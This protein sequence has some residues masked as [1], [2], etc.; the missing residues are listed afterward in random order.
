M[1]NENGRETPELLLITLLLRR[2]QIDGLHFA[3]LQQLS[4]RIRTERQ[5]SVSANTLA[6]MSGLRH[7]KRKTYQHNL[8]ALSKAYG[9]SSWRHYINFLNERNH[10]AFTNNK[11]NAIAFISA[12]T[13]EAARS[14]DLKFI[15]ALEQYV[16]SKGIEID[17]F[18]SI[19]YGLMR[20]LR[21]NPNPERII[22]YSI[23][24]PVLIELFYETYVDM[25]YVNGYFGEAMIALSQ[26]QTASTQRTLFS[27]AIAYLCE[28]NREK[29]SASKKRGHILMAYDA[30]MVCRTVY[31]GAA[32][33]VARWLRV[34][35]EFSLQHRE[36]RYANLLFDAAVSLIDDVTADDAIVLISELTEIDA[37][38]VPLTYLSKLN[39]LFQQVRSQ[40]YFEIDCLLNSALNLSIKMERTDLITTAEAMDM[41]AKHK[42][43]FCTRS[44]SMIKKIKE[45]SNL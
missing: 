4:D 26:S 33:P 36:Q 10:L 37:R 40:V 30:D 24:S 32:Y 20:G 13:I 17:D 27:N 44:S 19:G 21:M 18:F 42:A 1:K 31:N 7:D 43:R 41:I 2:Y 16:T 25:D 5:L 11:E 39:E 6:R 35:I 15:S 22:D 3:G 23:Q 45:L 28:K 29:H 14:N 8:D 34:C 9:F 38:A 12:Y